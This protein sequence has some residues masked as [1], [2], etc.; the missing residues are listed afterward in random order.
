[1]LWKRQETLP[2]LSCSSPGAVLCCELW[3]LLD[4]LLDDRTCTAN[5]LTMVRLTMKQLHTLLY[6]HAVFSLGVT[7]SKHSNLTNY[8]IKGNL[9]CLLKRL[10]ENIAHIIIYAIVYFTP[11]WVLCRGQASGY[12]YLYAYRTYHLHIHAITQK[13]LHNILDTGTYLF[14]RA[15]FNSTHQCTVRITYLSTQ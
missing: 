3:Q 11:V 7:T 10:V 2:V 15:T 14:E 1:M 4:V 9:E 12:R 6:K 8:Y 13:G 5:K